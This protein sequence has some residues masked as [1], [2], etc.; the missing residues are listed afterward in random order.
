M[1]A[2]Q[3][4]G[5][6]LPHPRVHRAAARPGVLRRAGHRQPGHGRP[7]GI[8]L[9]F[10]RRIRS[11]TPTGFLTKVVTR[12]VDTTVNFFHRHS[13]IKEY[14]KDGRALRVETVVNSPT[15]LGVLR[16]LPHLP[17][18]V[19]KARDANDRLLPAQR[20]GQGCVL[21]RPAFERIALP[22]LDGDGRRAPALRFGDPRVMGLADALS[23]A[24]GVVTGFTNRSL[25]AHVAGLLD[26]DYTHRPDGLQLHRLSRNGIIE[27]I[28]GTH[29]YHLTADG[30]RSAIFYTK[31][32]HRLLR[33][34]LHANALPAPTELRDALHIID[35]HVHTHLTGARIG[36]P[37][38]NKRSKPTSG[39]PSGSKINVRVRRTKLR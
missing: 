5:R 17:E 29:T 8:S 10:D 25:R 28:H 37:P 4:P 13:R 36:E 6:D 27:R 11:D 3:A 12:A 38:K 1:G 9:V 31:L 20:V 34:L 14:L 2:V 30:Q 18:L 15:D 26:T 19:A 7:D 21:A 33:P 35:Q 32:Q 22:S 24:L 39:S 16:R 23:A